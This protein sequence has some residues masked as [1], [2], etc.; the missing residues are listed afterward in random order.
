MGTILEITP[1]L[2]INENELVYSF[3]QSSGPGG[4]NVNKVSTAVRLR[5]NAL[6]SESLSAEIKQR[7]IRLAGRRLNAQGEIIIEAR[8]YRTQELNRQAARLHLVSL[9]QMAAEPPKTRHRTRPTLASKQRRL[10]EKK[11]RG[12]TKRMRRSFLEE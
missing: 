4:Q 3:F 7:L 8:Q 11:K 5:F 6:A 2:S 9:L 1:E 10:V 12:E